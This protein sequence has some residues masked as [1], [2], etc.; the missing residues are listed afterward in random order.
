MNANVQLNDTTMLAE[1]IEGIVNTV[2][3]IASN[4]Q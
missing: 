3:I 1:L 4:T 2:S